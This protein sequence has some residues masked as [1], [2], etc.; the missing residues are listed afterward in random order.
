MVHLTLHQQH[1]P[2]VMANRAPDKRINEKIS[3]LPCK[4]TELVGTDWNC[5]TEAIPISTHKIC[6]DAKIK[7]KSSSY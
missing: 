2:Q 3:E 5:L 6:F 7:K 4:K 1:L